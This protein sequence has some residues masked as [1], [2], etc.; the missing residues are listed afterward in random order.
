MV[1]PFYSEGRYLYVTLREIGPEIQRS[2]EDGIAQ[3]ARNA[4]LEVD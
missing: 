3:V 2:L 4:G 1:R